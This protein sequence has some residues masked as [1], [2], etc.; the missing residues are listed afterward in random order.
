MIL[1]TENV[2]V[3]L[4]STTNF[5]DKFYIRIRVYQ[6]YHALHRQNPTRGGASIIVNNNISSYE[7]E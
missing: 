3:C 7:I 1:E 4:I 6:I 2:D 5:T